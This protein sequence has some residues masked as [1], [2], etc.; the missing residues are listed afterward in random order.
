MVIIVIEVKLKLAN[1]ASVVNVF[2]C[3]VLYKFIFPKKIQI[4]F[5]PF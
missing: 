3:N 4:S 1:G 2:M 5:A